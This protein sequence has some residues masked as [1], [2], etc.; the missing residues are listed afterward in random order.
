[1]KVIVYGYRYKV[2]D[3]HDPDKHRYLVTKGKKCSCGYVKCEHIK[4]V[5]EYLQKGGKRAQ[6]EPYDPRGSLEAQ[7]LRIRAL[8]ERFISSNTLSEATMALIE[9]QSVSAPE[10][11]IEWIKAYSLPQMWPVETV[12]NQYGSVQE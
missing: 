4:A 3:V 12:N 7:L 9:A 2:W 1:M 8:R 5:Q 6:D 10:Q 11:R